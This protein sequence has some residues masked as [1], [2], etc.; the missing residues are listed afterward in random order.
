M[1]KSKL[2]LLAPCLL[3][4]AMP[5]AGCMTDPEIETQAF[6]PHGGSKQH[7]IKVVNGR[8]VVENCGE[9]TE[10]VS[11]TATNEMAENHGCAVQ[12]N[13]AAMA[14]YPADLTG[15]NRKLPKPLGDVQYSAIKK[16]TGSVGSSGGGS[17]SG[18][19][20][21]EGGGAAPAE[22]KP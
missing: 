21:A 13:I 10:D 20:S 14:A 1:Y 7:P 2:N 5:L 15:K 8:A 11:Y 6:R 16:I 3:V 22:P 9:W 18:G 4:L 17:S 19:T 12:A